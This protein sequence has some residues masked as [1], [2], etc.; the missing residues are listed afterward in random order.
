M[1]NYFFLS[2]AKDSIGCILL[3]SR[4]NWSF[5]LGLVLNLTNIEMAIAISVTK[6]IDSVDRKIALTLAV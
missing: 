2:F 3:K 4:T 1:T 6:L 5:F